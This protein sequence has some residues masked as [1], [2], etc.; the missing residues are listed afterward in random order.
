MQTCHFVGFGVLWFKANAC[1]KKVTN[2]YKLRHLKECVSDPI[3]SIPRLTK[4]GGISSFTI[5]YMS[6]LDGSN[7]AG[8]LR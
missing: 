5:S 1:N 2:L 6:I 8:A 3:F 7:F 4:H